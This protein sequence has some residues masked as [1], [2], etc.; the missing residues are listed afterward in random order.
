MPI[1]IPAGAIHRDEDYYPNPNVFNPDNFSPEKVAE[2]ES[3]LFLPF[4]EGPRNCIGLRFGKMQ[5]V[6]GLAL[7]LK[8]FKFS[9]CDETQIPLTYNKEAFLLSTDKGIHL[10]VTKI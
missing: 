10:K 7:L 9:V 8:N 3:V 2:R 4:G 6:I 1:I 5:A